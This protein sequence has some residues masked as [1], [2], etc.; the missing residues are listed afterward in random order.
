MGYLEV[1]TTVVGRRETSY[2]NIGMKACILD[3]A[4]FQNY[5]W[6]KLIT[7]CATYV[8]E[9]LYAGTKEYGNRCEN[10]KK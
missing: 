9:D 3:P 2:K 7:N 1:R 6:Q 4:M 5:L 10:T 8:D